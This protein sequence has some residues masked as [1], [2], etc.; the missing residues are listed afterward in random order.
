MVGP[1]GVARRFRV[2][3]IY[4]SEEAAGAARAV[5]AWLLRRA[6]D[7]LACIAR[8]TAKLHKT[9]NVGGGWPGRC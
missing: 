7:A 3:Y 8:L 1:D 6:E 5:P 9:P 2:L 4:G